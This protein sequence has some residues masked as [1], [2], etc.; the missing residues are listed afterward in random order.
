MA[1]LPA[2]ASVEYLRKAA[3][4]VAKDRS[5]KLAEAQRAL[6]NEYG[7]PTWVDLL[8]R[9]ADVQE[10]RRATRSFI[11]VVRSGDVAAVRVLLAAGSN[12][13]LGDGR[14]D[15]LHV[16]A[17]RGPLAMVEALIAGGAL[18][19][20]RDHAGRTPLEVARRGRSPD[21]EAIVAL[22]DRQAIPDPAFRAAVRAI[23]TGDVAGLERI[24]DARPRLL[25]ERNV[26]PE[27]YREA[28]R[29]DYF[30]DPKL[31]WYVAWNP[32]PDDPIP[33]NITEIARVMIARGV[34][35][36]DLTYTLG[37]VMSGRLVREA[38]HQVT[39]ARM[40]LAAGAELSRET[41]LTAAAH[42][43]LDVLRALV[44]DGHPV[45][46]LLAAALGDVPALRAAL[47]HA[48]P[49]DLHAAFSLAVINHHLEAV[50]MTLDAGADV[51]AYLAVHNHSTALHQAAL[52][53]AIEIV[54]LLAERGAR[55][56]RRDRLWDATPHDWT[57][58]QGRPNGQAALERI[59][60]ARNP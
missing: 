18:V 2:R 57:I 35:R 8:D 33:E 43:E 22:L 37:L 53:E 5:V 14:E 17:R 1:E 38:G 56:D 46:A 54:E 26:G 4:R 24:L 28:K 29:G 21:R 6:A 34:D 10:E 16:A 3:K 47:V 51:N 19:W 32:K 31:F 44:A 41:I 11:A 25:H 60:R 36:E 59:E 48:T 23:R 40:I 49:D 13:R 42:R 27:V 12:P 55:T 45:D 7:F 20:T 39:L 52:D 50:R 58:H 9:V 30:R 15:P